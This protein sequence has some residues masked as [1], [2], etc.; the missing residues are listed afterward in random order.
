MQVR[1]SQEKEDKSTV[2]LA[3]VKAHLSSDKWA[4]FME[5]KLKVVGYAFQR[6]ISFASKGYFEFLSISTL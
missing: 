1:I 4:M 2:Y 6:A 5:S 3:I